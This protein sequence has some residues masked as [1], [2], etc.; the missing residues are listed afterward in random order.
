MF[1]NVQ[2]T[3]NYG[4]PEYEKSCLGADNESDSEDTCC[5]LDRIEERLSRLERVLWAMIQHR[6]SVH[7][8]TTFDYVE[9]WLSTTTVPRSCSGNTLGE[10]S[11]EFA[12][13]LAMEEAMAT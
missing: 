9:S 12:S 6:Q 2:V 7:E 13:D 3:Q 4:Q 5:I 11:T 8:R 10:Q 1:R